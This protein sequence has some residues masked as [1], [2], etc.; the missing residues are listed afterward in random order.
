MTPKS[1]KAVQ[2]KVATP[3]G[4]RYVLCASQPSRHYTTPHQGANAPQKGA[5]D[6][7]GDNGFLPRH[8]DRSQ[9]FLKQIRGFYWA[10]QPQE[11]LLLQRTLVQFPIPTWWLTIPIV[12][13]SSSGTLIPSDLHRYQVC[14]WNIYIHS[15]KSI[16]TQK[17]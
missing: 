2:V 4:A 14:M 8:H 16:H 7:T 3:A 15:S 17:V 11:S 1:S 6:L 13:K 12:C 10:A 5:C 9:G